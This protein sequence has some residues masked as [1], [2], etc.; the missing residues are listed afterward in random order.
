V[1]GTIV[2]SVS[3]EPPNQIA[4]ELIITI[5]AMERF[6]VCQNNDNSLRMTKGLLKIDLIAR[7]IVPYQINLLESS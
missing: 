5:I 1:Q 4:K 3:E 7:K 2:P 6:R